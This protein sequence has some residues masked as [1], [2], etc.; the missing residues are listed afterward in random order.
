M[1]LTIELNNILFPIDSI[2]D[3]RSLLQK[4]PESRELI[5]NKIQA[6]L[7]GYKK[8]SGALWIIHQPFPAEEMVKL[9]PEKEEV[10]F[11]GLHPTFKFNGSLIRKDDAGHLR[12]H[13]A[14]LDRYL[15]IC[16]NYK[17][18][19]KNLLL[20]E[21]QPSASLAG[22]LKSM[23]PQPTWD[24]LITCLNGFED[25]QCFSDL[26]FILKDFRGH[27]A[28][29]LTYLNKDLSK[30]QKLVN[31]IRTLSALTFCCPELEDTIFKIFVANPV[32]FKAIVHGNKNISDANCNYKT[33][34]MCFP[35]YTIMNTS[36]DEATTRI[37]EEGDKKHNYNKI[38][39]N[40]LLLGKRNSSFF[41]AKDI[42][43]EIASFASE[44]DNKNPL[45]L[46][47]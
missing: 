47:K 33:L 18:Q 38:S 28:A 9:F 15:K 31:D 20:N 17:S 45:V 32:H 23:P 1:Q 37:E 14:A 41:G 6:P 13:R 46:R 39:K 11:K 10:Y 3:L 12:F 24:Q 19:V 16:P 7:E 21:L 44:Y 30:T 27:G 36:V 2:E 42:V 22:V 8:G 40:L 4:L 5:F 43:F 26:M 35:N 25:V 34:K 29:I